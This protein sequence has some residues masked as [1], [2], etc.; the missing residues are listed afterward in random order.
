MGNE[1]TYYTKYF[2]K[3]FSEV[4]WKLDK[5]SKEK[6]DKAVEKIRHRPELGKPLHPPY[7]GYRSERIERWRLIY[8]LVGEVVV[9]ARLDNRNHVYG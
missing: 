3:E 1:K 6:I 5:Q 2:S 9:F 4:Y 8:R 7:A